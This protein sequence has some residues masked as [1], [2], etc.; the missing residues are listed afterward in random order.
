[1]PSGVAR[2]FYTGWV[3]LFEQL[4]WDV[5]AKFSEASDIDAF[6]F[7]SFRDVCGF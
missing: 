1:M 2:I 3:G 5:V 4:A 7:E 6:P